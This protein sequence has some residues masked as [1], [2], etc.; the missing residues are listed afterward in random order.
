MPDLIIGAKVGYLW[1]SSPRFEDHG[2]YLPQDL[3]V[4]LVAYNPNMKPANVSTFVSN[5][6][7][8]ST[9]VQAL[10]L[11]LAQLDGFRNEGTPSLPGI[12]S[13]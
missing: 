7:V 13:A 10:G 2:G 6:Q 12:F 9:M 8:A 4:P 3:N 5:R 1:A 11:P